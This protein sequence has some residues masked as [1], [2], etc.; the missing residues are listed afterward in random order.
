MAICDVPGCQKEA[1]ASIEEL[2]LSVCDWHEY[3]HSNEL[4]WIGKQDEDAI[5]NTIPKM[6]DNDDVLNNNE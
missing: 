5:E 3:E 2:S 1:T 4:K 6:K